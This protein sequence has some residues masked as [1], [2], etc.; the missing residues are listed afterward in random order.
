[1]G[2]KLSA[3]DLK[4]SVFGW[5]V[6]LSITNAT[7]RSSNANFLSCSLTHSLNNSESIQIFFYAWYRH[8]VLLIASKQRGLFDFPITNIGIF[9]HTCQL[10]QGKSAQSCYFCLHYISRISNVYFLSE[11][12]YK[13]NQTRLHCICHRSRNRILKSLF[14][15]ESGH[16]I[17]N[18]LT[19]T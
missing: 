5:A 19:L 17:G 4:L 10:Q 15:P 12:L 13:I 7:L 8:G 3:I 18:I 6:Q 14:P 9:P 1:M 16:F 11:V 2:R